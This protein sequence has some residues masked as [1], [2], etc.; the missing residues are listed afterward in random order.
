MAYGECLI[1]IFL[2]KRNQI[3]FDNLTHLQKQIGSVGMEEFISYLTELNLIKDVGG[4]FYVKKIFYGL[5]HSG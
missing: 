2:D 1:K 5:E 4:E 3:L